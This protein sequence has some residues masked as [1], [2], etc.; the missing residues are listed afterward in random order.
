MILKHAA[1]PEADTLPNE[2]FFLKGRVFGFLCPQST[3]FRTYQALGFGLWYNS[4]CWKF[5]DI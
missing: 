4:H 2:T 1:I 3:A 5:K